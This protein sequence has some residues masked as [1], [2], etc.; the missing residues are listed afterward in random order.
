MQGIV[1]SFI[2]RA[3]SVGYIELSANFGLARF[4]NFTVHV[5]ISQFYCAMIY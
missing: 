4:I 5:D 1:N 2:K 3:I